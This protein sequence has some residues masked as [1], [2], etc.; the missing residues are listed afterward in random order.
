M[1]LRLRILNHAPKQVT[2]RL[3]WN[4]PAGWETVAADTQVTIPTHQEGASRAVF[5]AQGAGLHV[6]TADVEFGSR[7][8]RE[9]AEALV[10]VA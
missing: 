1:T 4:I 2:Y 5:R 6:L 10:Q 8:L 7:Q 9:W 3:K